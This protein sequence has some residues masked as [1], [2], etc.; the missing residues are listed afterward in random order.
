MEGSV[1]VLDEPS[2]NKSSNRIPDFETLAFGTGG[3]FEDV[4]SKI[5]TCGL[6]IFEDSP[7]PDLLVIRSVKMLLDLCRN[8]DRGI[9]RTGSESLL[10]P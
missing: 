10:G 8:F 2:S 4:T 6:P 1:V 9:A 7:V 3:E 5:A